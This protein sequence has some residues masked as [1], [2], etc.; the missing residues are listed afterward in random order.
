[1]MKKSKKSILEVDVSLFDVSLSEKALFAKH[2]AVMLRSGMPITE[3]LGI[4]ADSAQGN[5]EKNH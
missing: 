2:L 5:N 3:A 1:M 4:F